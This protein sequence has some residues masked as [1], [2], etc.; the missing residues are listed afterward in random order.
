MAVAV[1]EA[2]PRVLFVG[3]TTHDLPLSPSLAR[4]WDAVSHSLDIRIV[5]RAGQITGGGDERFHLVPPLRG[6]PGGLGFYSRLPRIVRR[7]SRAFNPDVVIAQS[8]FEAFASLG[9]LRSQRPRP[10]LVVELHGDY[11]LAARHYGSR[12][13]RSYAKLADRAARFALRHADATR[14]VS[15]AMG[16]LAESATGTAP[17]AIFPTYFDLTGFTA[18]PPWP[19]PQRPTALWVGAF[20][21]VK[22]PAALAEAWRLVALALP[23]ARLVVVGNG[24]VRTELEQLAHDLG[25]SVELRGRL[26]VEQVV[27]AFDSSTVLCLTSV[28][29]GLPRVALEAFARARPVVA[30]DVGGLGDA[31]KS[32]RNGRLVPRRDVSGLADALT[33]VLGDKKLAGRLGAQG[34]ADLRQLVS[35]PEHYA[36][37]LTDLV[38]G[39]AVAGSA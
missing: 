34:N 14:A 25:E 29:E 38:R 12:M 9:A 3:S 2:R 17:A 6:H 23:E 19:L 30:F 32:G 24:P 31:V 16:Q 35:S 39:L 22:D 21:S 11:G 20:Q 37:E 4:K 15:G 26:P 8:P 13:R 28:S 1:A 27:E 18:R 36:E 7:E 10:K 33:E 5:A